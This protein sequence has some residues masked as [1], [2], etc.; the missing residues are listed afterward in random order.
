MRFSAPS[1]AAQGFP[2]LRRC[3]VHEQSSQD[4]FVIPHWTRDLAKA[5]ASNGLQPNG[6]RITGVGE[7][8]NLSNWW[9]SYPSRARLRWSSGIRAHGMRGHVRLSAKSWAFNRA[10]RRQQ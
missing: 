2:H 9:F 6:R 7:R 8:H 5:L 10:W 1:S 4:P 3:Q